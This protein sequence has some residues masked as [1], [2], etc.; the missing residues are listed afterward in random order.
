MKHRRLDAPSVL[1][2]L[3]FGLVLILWV[4]SYALTVHQYF[5]PGYAHEIIRMRGQVI[6]Y[7]WVNGRQTGIEEIDWR[8]LG[9]G[10]Y[11]QS[12]LRISIPFWFQALLTLIVP[13]YWLRS[14]MAEWSRPSVGLCSKCGYDLRAT[15]ER[16]P[17]CGGL[18]K[19][20]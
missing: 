13:A 4:Q 14:I 20:I 16:C 3:L 18:P 17:E 6:Y 9:F 10:Y 8:Y 12:C 11:N 7:W 15:P 2:L 1:S 5:G 19:K